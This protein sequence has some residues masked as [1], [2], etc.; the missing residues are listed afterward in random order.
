MISYLQKK[1]RSGLTICEDSLTSGIFDGF[2][3]LPTEIF[4]SIL[5][6]SLYHD[7]LPNNSGEL[8]AILFWD[9]WNAD[10]T[11][12]SNFVEPDVLLQFDEFDVLIEAKRYDNFQQSQSQI[13]KE[14]IAYINTYGDEKKLYFIQLGGL[15]HKFDEQNIIEKG[16]NV[17]MLKTDW[18]K[19]L[20][21]VV[22]QINT[23]QSSP[24]SSLKA[25]CRILEDIR[26]V[27]EM[28][29]F[30]EIQWLNSILDY[31]VNITS[32]NS[33][34]YLKLPHGKK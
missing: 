4:Y 28:H 19:L 17:I 26:K 13:K 10:G 22:H 34:N 3:Y 2:K 12:N 25:Y 21:E 31:K 27:F 20:H 16:F 33:F 30:Y 11:S 29:N 24:L 9:K 23:L 18:T 5:K 15:H 32:F 1:G 14:I 6:N 8:N 7:K